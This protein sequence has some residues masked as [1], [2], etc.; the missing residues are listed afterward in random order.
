MKLK[1]AVLRHRFAPLAVRMIKRGEVKAIMELICVQCGLCVQ[2]PVS[3]SIE[4]DDHRAYFLD[5]KP[6]AYFRLDHA[7]EVVPVDDGSPYCVPGERA[8]PS[9]VPGDERRN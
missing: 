9:Y 3:P 7:N 6:P 1:D 2:V 5:D 8:K 4:T